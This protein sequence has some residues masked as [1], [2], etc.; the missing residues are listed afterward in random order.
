MAAGEACATNS[1][2]PVFRLN[3]LDRYIFKSVLYTCAAA[4]G[5]FTFIVLVPNVVKDMLAYVLTGQLSVAVFAR[6][7]ITLLPLALSYAL[8]MGMLTGVL[9]TL[10]R[11]SADSEITAMRAV[12]LSVRRIVRP[13]LVLAVLGAALG[14][15]LN[16]QSMPQ[17]RVEYERGF[18]AA[19]QANPLNLIVPKTFIRDFPGY[20]VYVGAKQGGDL[21]DFWL[22]EL[23]PEGRVR[24][25]VRAASGRFDYDRAKNSF[26]LT[27]TQAQVESRSDKNPEDFREPQLVGSFEESEAVEL[28]LDRF[29]GR[30]SGVRIKPEWLTYAELQAERQRVAAQPVPTDPAEAALARREQTKLAMVFHDK[31]NTAIAVFSLALIGVPLGIKVSRRETSANFAVAVGLTLAYYL[32]TVLIKI[33]DGR[34]EL[35]PDLLLWLPNLLVIGFAA[36]LMVRIERR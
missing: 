2:A 15:Y 7:V 10:G 30:G 20:V 24:R 34:P 1:A 26:L 18:A 35:R 22:W 33:L 16:F 4:V 31:V 5:L 32:M 25:V 6:L 23:D 29:F 28:S 17:A 12:G 27:L 3:L 36:W 14:I 8:P 13:I 9:L 11:L 21:R 19:I